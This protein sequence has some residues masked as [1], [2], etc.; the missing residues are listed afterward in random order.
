MA[1]LRQS[2]GKVVW[3]VCDELVDLNLQEEFDASPLN[4]MGF[5]DMVASFD[6]GWQGRKSGNSYNSASGFAS[7]MGARMRK[8]MARC[9]KSK[10]SVNGSCVSA[11][12]FLSIENICQPQQT[13]SKL[14]RGL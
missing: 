6:M 1:N 2:V 11:S 12:N 4:T 3:T 7:F 10:L 13:T 8:V 9:V 14:H 5:K